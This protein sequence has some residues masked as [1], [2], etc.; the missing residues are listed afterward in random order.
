MKSIDVTVHEESITGYTVEVPDDFNVD[1]D[2]LM[3]WLDGARIN[4]QK[5][6]NFEVEEGC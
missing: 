3:E 6:R 4:W 1:E 2:D 5:V